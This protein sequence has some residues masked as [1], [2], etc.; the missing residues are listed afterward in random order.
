MDETKSNQYDFNSHELID[1]KDSSV[2]VGISALPRSKDAIH[3]WNITEND[4]EVDPE[5]RNPRFR[6][7][8]LQSR[9]TRWVHASEKVGDMC[10]KI[11]RRNH[12]HIRLLLPAN[13]I[14]GK[15]IIGD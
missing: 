2:D 11:M 15:L 3:F 14:N 5:L 12:F 7:S 13:V 6:E 8:M 10:Q 4:E 9:L 1:E